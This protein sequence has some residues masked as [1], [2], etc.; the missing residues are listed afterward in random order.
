M[1]PKFKTMELTIERT[2]PASPSKVFRAWLNPKVP[3]NPWHKM[4]KLIFNPRV[5]GFFYRMHLDEGVELPH[6]GRFLILERSKKIQHT[7][8]SKH[9]H[10]I[11]SVLKRFSLLANGLG[12][13]AIT[14]LS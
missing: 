5:G 8:M 13:I 10:G 4:D 7:W 11:E 1:I 6:Y 3:G 2:I 12:T 9:T 14:I